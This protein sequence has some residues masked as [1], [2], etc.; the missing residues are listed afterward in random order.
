MSRVIENYK[1]I[2][3]SEFQTEGIFTI[4]LSK[5]DLEHKIIAFPTDT[6]FGVGALIDDEIAIDKIF[7]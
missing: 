1:Y 7:E 5:I 4:K 2:T 3:V 6:V